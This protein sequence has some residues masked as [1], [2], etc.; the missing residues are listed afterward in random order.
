MSPFAR[1]I[2]HP[3][4]DP[5]LTYLNDD[6]QS[7]EPEWYLP[8]VPMLL[9]NGG[10][11]IG[12]GWSTSLPNYNPRD[13]VANI[14]KLMNEEALEPMHPWY[15]G[16]KGTIVQENASRY[17][18]SGIIN[19]IDS[20]TIEITELP[21]KIW[22][23]TYKE[24]LEL[25]I[26]GSDKQPAW[27]KD[28]REYHTDSKVHFVITLTE[29]SMKAAE[30]EGLE[31]K[32]KL[33]STL[34]T[35]NIVNFDLEGRIRK[36]A[37]VNEIMHHF[38]D[39]RKEYYMK[40]KE[41]MLGQLTFEL[42]RLENKVRFVMEIIGGQLKV[43]NRKKKEL[44]GEL[45]ARKY[46]PITKNSVQDDVQNEE[47]KEIE[48][49]GYDYLLSMPI[50]SLTNEKVESLT[51]EKVQKETQVQLLIGKTPLDLWRTDLDAFMEKWTVFIFVIVGIRIS[52]GRPG[53]S[54]A[55]PESGYGQE[56][57]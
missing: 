24:Q 15:R 50:W 3:S 56:E 49:H 52:H 55:G 11:G 37:D 12:T 34:S 36:Y 17:R 10:E 38:F 40:R 48:T 8:I 28:Y 16:F 53:I 19:K 4:D 13:I 35:S 33:V 23:Q 14:Y 57:C 46:A 18:V 20:T 31:Q 21:L 25:W 6:G 45:K 5:L 22:T 47:E 32:F 27:I 44:L 30:K 41:Q 54:R 7:I 39:L 9:I 29:E 51:S 26:A 1:L 43:Q 2:Y 42:T